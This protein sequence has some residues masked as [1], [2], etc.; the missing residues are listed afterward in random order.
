MTEKKSSFMSCLGGPQGF[1]RARVRELGR[2]QVEMHAYDVYRHGCFLDRA[3]PDGAEVWVALGDLAPVR[4]TVIAAAG[5]VSECEFYTS[6]DAIRLRRLRPIRT[7]CSPAPAP[8]LLL[9]DHRRLE[10]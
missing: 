9:T 6:F 10:G 3:F 8:P 7:P 4:A 1:V 2:A 5:G